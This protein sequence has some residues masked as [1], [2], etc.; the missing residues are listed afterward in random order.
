MKP[1]HQEFIDS[2]Q[3]N[4]IDDLTFG[5]EVEQKYGI[6]IVCKE[7]N[8]FDLYY[9]NGNLIAWYNYE[10]TCGYIF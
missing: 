5:E 4:N 1:R 10:A 9:L 6:D 7:D 3:Y 8:I 2:N